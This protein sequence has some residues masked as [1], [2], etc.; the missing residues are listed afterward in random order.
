VPKS[1]KQARSV[2]F[3]TISARGITESLDI[4]QSWWVLLPLAYS[5][6]IPRQSRVDQTDH[7]LAMQLPSEDLMRLWKLQLL[8]G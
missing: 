5:A 1:C 2:E 8:F 4:V 6:I 7:D 3:F